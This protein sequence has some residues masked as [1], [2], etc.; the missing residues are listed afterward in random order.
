MVTGICWISTRYLEQSVRSL[1]EGT[2]VDPVIQVPT[3]TYP[4][5]L[6]TCVPS[7]TEYCVPIIL[8]EQIL[9]VHV[10]HI[11]GEY[12]EKRYTCHLNFH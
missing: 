5:L 7:A 4:S 12:R 9:T 6:L 10:S 1:K 11:P 2:Y 8:S 3:G